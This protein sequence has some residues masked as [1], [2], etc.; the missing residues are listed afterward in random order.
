VELF[1]VRVPR[2]IDLAFDFAI[3]REG[4]DGIIVEAK[5]GGQQYEHTIAQLRTYRAA[6]PRLPGA[7][8]LIWGIVEKPDRPDAT[9]EKLRS[10]FANAETDSDVW[11]FSSA[12][13]IPTVLEAARL[14]TAHGGGVP[15]RRAGV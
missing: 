2:F 5:S 3:R 13:S 8:L 14:L 9:F 12:D 11:V 1:Q 15:G 4:L 10:M 7:R 6:R